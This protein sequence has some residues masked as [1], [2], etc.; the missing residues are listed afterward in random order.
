MAAISAVSVT[1]AS[2]EKDAVP[3]SVGI[4]KRV[5]WVGSEYPDSSSPKSGNPRIKGRR[6][7][8]QM[9]GGIGMSKHVFL[10][11]FYCLIIL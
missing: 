10:R 11:V 4:G 2:Q 5:R 3:G 1:Q 8:R 6:M 9:I 7:P